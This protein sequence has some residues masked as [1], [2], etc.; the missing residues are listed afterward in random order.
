MFG[1]KE[2]KLSLEKAVSGISAQ[3]AIYINDYLYVIGDNEII[4]L[5]ETNWQ[6]AGSLEF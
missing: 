2:N 1:Y 4:V 3:R 5:D 6:K